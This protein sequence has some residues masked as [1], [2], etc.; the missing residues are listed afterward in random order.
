MKIPNFYLRPKTGPNLL[1]ISVTPLHPNFE[2]NCGTKEPLLIRA[3]QRALP[4]P[5]SPTI[6]AKCLPSGIEC[7]GQGF[8]R[9]THAPYPNSTCQLLIG[10]VTSGTYM[11]TAARFQRARSTWMC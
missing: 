3:C 6:D 2:K 8:L 9:R 4:A 11:T 7:S 10:G 1:R 5:R